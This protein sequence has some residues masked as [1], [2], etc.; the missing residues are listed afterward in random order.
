MFALN[1]L[2]ISAILSTPV[3][4]IS[5]AEA[6]TERVWSDGAIA[7]ALGLVWYLFC[8][9]LI[10]IALNRAIQATKRGSPFVLPLLSVGVV[11]AYIL[12]LGFL[13]VR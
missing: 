1:T 3:I 7:Y 8:A 4:T 12:Q 9:F 2:P 10:G 13:F 11:A 5:V 6:I